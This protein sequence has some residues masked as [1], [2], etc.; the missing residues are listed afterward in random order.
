MGGKGGLNILPQK[1]WNVYNWDN[2][3]KVIE[4]EKIVDKEIE[5][6]ERK[7]KDKNLSDKAKILKR[8]GDL[9]LKKY[10][11][12]EEEK[13]DKNKIF[14]EVM[15]RKSMDKR[16]KVDM[17]FESRN[18][19]MKSE[20]QLKLFEMDE[21]D[22]EKYFEEKES[23][24]NITFKE[25]IKNHLNPWYIRKRKEELKDHFKIDYKFLGKKHA[26]NRVESKNN[27]LSQLNEPEYRDQVNSYK[28]IK[29]IDELRRERIEREKK[30]KEKINF[31]MN[32]QINKKN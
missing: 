18:K 8:G 5:R 14:K 3:I 16:L 31:F 28:K 20:E 7:R 4:N 29:S 25:S 27:D 12:S 2:R 19:P 32:S 13:Y 24:D 9:N 6:M 26:N 23:H 15:Q 10:N 22:A 30:E 21:K 1:K 17:L 11:F